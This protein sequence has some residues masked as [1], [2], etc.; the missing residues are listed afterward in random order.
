[1]GYKAKIATLEA[2]EGFRSEIQLYF[3]QLSNTGDDSAALAESVIE[4]VKERIKDFERLHELK[5]EV[6]RVAR[7]IAAKKLDKK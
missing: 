1:M 7:E 5:K 3:H 6:F 2:L 4:D